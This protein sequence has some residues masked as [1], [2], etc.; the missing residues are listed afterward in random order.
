MPD[1]EPEFIQFIF[2]SNSGVA[3][4]KQSLLDLCLLLYFKKLNSV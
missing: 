3:L 2:R 1:Y 4:F